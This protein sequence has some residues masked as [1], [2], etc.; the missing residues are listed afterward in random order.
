MIYVSTKGHVTALDKPNIAIKQHLNSQ[1]AAKNEE[2]QAPLKEQAK[3]Q[4]TKTILISLPEIVINDL[5]T[6]SQCQNKPIEDLIWDWFWNDIEPY[7]NV[8]APRDP[9]NQAVRLMINPRDDLELTLP[10]MIMHG[11]NAYAKNHETPLYYM[12]ED[13]WEHSIR[14]LL[15]KEIPING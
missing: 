3:R 1:T 9:Y 7:K 4:H 12:I 14:P 2:R 6:Y 5:E 8:K 10:K 11:L 13:W 15:N